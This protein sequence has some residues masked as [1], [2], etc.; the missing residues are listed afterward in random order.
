MTDVITRIW[1]LECHSR[2][3]V[4]FNWNEDFVALYFDDSQMEMVAR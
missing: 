2:K 4:R 1:P 3:R